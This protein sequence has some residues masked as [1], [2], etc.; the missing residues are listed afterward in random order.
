MQLFTRTN[1]NTVKKTIAIYKQEIKREKSSFIK[2][3][4]FIPA[5]DTLLLVMLPLLT[6]FL[7]QSL[8]TNPTNF[9]H[10][11]QLISGMC[12]VIVLG[13]TFNIHGYNNLFRH[14]ERVITRLLTK[15]SDEILQHSFQFFSK[16]K[17]GALA[18]DINNFSRSY[19]QIM[20]ALAMQA[21]RLVVDILMS[22]IVIAFIAP[23]LLVPVIL[24]TVFVI[25][26]II[27][28]NNHR[29]VHRNKRK[30]LQSKLLGSIADVFGN[31]TL[32]R[33]FAKRKYEVKRL[34]NERKS[35]E[36]VTQKEI[37]I[38]QKYALYRMATLY[39]MQVLLLILCAYLISHAMIS[40]AAVVFIITYLSRFT[41]A[42]FTVN[43]IVRNI[44]QAFL[45]AAKVTEILDIPKEIID[46]KYAP[47]LLVKHGDIKFDN[48]MFAYDDSKDT[49]VFSNLTVHIPAGQRIGL[50]GKS[51]GGKTTL[52][53][54]LLRYMDITQ[55]TIAIDNQNIVEITQDSLRDAIAYVPQDPY[56]F[57]R[58]LRENISYGKLDASD[59]QIIDAAKK[60][61]AW[62]FIDKL[63][64][65]IDTVVGE[66]GVKLSGGQRQR[67]AIA[68]A[69]L[70]DAPILV[71]DE[72]TS[73]LDSESEHL[74]QQSLEKLMHG[75]TSIVVAHRLSTIS[76]LDRIIVLE[77]GEVI[78]DGSHD[79][80]LANDNLYAKL[81]KRQSGGFIEE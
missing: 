57:H 73:A 6:S 70:K 48:V 12:A 2:T 29:A 81:W 44:E 16:Q 38:L 53:S 51:G 18:G 13:L 49:A 67:I 41:G 54:L 75:R 79:E 43:G 61:Y 74:I 39:G 30:E 10:A 52:T 71:L 7:V 3:F 26:Q 21:S 76:K 4:I 32:V 20:D 63:P 22:L 15:A 47:E 14:E 60:A 42:A 72:A 17:V 78:E 25:F 55:G 69:F 5:S 68:R 9:T 11:L 62:E 50:V 59:E 56:L 37:V 19:M 65:G 45:D 27:S 40:I 24:M 35:I 80:L 36:A 66:R 64:N 33:M 77:N 1:T 23:V 34:T 58:T 8:I 31:Q 28:S 46:K